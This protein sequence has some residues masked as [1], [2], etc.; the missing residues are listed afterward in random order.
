MATPTFISRGNQSSG[1][2]R[3]SQLLGLEQTDNFVS[4][5]GPTPMLTVKTMPKVSPALL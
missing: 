3:K 2:S 4:A 1:Q 5:A